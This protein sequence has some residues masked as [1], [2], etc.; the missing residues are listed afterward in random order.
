MPLLPW[1]LMSAAIPT[2]APPLQRDATGDPLPRGARARL[3]T[4]RFRLVIPDEPGL[5][6]VLS[7]D[8]KWMACPAA[9]GAI[10]LCSTADGRE[11]LQVTGGSNREHLG[12]IS[13]DGRLLATLSE[14]GWVRVWDA[15][16]G[17]LS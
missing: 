10:R 15:N 7:P 14:D 9:S 3:G 16:S 2:C 5:P 4:L 17:Q 6:L 8:R 1:L 11:L 12:A 13:G